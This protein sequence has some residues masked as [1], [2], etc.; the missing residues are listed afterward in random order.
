MKEEVEGSEHADPEFSNDGKES[1]L[2]HMYR[3]EVQRS[4][5]WRERIDSTTTWAIIVTAGILTW[6]FSSPQ[7][8]HIVTILGGVIVTFFSIIEARRYRY[9]D[10]WRTRVRVLEENVIAPSINPEEDG[11]S[12][13]WR[14]ALAED[15]EKPS[16]KMTNWEAWRRRMKR[17]YIW[18]ISFLFLSWIIKVLMHPE[19]SRTFS[20][21]VKS[22]STL[23]IPGWLVLVLVAVPYL[24]LLTAVIQEEKV[25][26][27]AKGAIRPKKDKKYNWKEV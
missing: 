13:K 6:V 1:L 3:G 11:K 7:N 12:S 15:L 16:F 9:F 26:R 24:I 19:V 25:S 20:H 8:P 5:T 17:N 4:N 22:A 27:E 14:K 10:I 23:G 18:I 21:F 2:T